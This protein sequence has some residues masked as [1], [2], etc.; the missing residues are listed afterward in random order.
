MPS[1][2]LPQIW[3]DYLRV[4]SRPGAVR[5]EDDNGEDVRIV[6]RRA[7]NRFPKIEIDGQP[8]NLGR[9]FAWYEWIWIGLP[10]LLIVVGGVIGA[11]VGALTAT[12][13]AHIFRTQKSVGVG[14]GFSAMSTVVGIVLW[15]AIS[16]WVQLLVFGPYSQ[17]RL[18][19]FAAQEN[20][21][22]PSLLDSETRRDGAR[23]G[24]HTFTLDRTLVHRTA[25]EMTDELLG[26]L[27]SDLMREACA[28]PNVAHMVKNDVTVTYVYR[29]REGKPIMS[30]PVTGSDC[31]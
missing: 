25:E 5:V 16:D 15:L 20:E 28:D 13:N 23:A 31:E 11:I 1:F 6:L 29:G 18:E 27:K 30:V 4:S 17:G 19:Y 22:A 12:Y 24:D 26:T 21:S 8:V 10:L 14:F 7:F 9:G 2:G 3:V